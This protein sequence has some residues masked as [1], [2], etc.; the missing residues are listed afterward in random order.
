MT[1]LVAP[2][3]RTPK[4][5]VVMANYNRARF[6][7]TAIESVL[8]QTY[9]NTEIIVSDDGSTDGSQDVIQ[10]LARQ[11][12]NI[13][14]IYAPKNQGI[15]FAINAGFGKCTGE[16]VIMFDSD[17]LM[18]PDKLATQ[19]SIL[20]RRPDC[21][22]CSHDEEI[23]DATGKVVGL[24]TAGRPM[25][26]GVEILFKTRWLLG[27]YYRTQKSSFLGRSSFMLASKYDSRLKIWNEW[28][29]M[30]D[31]MTITGYRWI[32]VPDVMGSYRRHSGQSTQDPAISR[33]SFEECMLVLAIASVRYPHLS[34]LVKN[35]RDFL[36]FDRL[37]FE[38]HE[39]DVRQDLERQFLREAGFQKWLY[40]KLAKTI[41]HNQRLMNATRPARLM[42]RRL[43]A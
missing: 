37:L 8:A 18:F 20:E 24:L 19:V 21:G 30:I 33:I 11:N 41:L 38:R 43:F 29:H 15:T 10:E 2:T 23:I 28:L 17:D 26:G 9:G 25:E 14:P 35:K 12:S 13:V 1:Q 31:C 39:P 32:H 7:R 4:I 36:L 34:R 6:I 40:L 42:M 22:I 3:G 16:Y 27:E 5:S